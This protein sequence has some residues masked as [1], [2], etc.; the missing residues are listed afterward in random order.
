MSYFLTHPAVAIVVSRQGS[1]GSTRCEYSALI[2]PLSGANNVPSFPDCC[3]KSPRLLATFGDGLLLVHNSGPQKARASRPIQHTN[4]DIMFSQD[5]IHTDFATFSQ[6]SFQGVPMGGPRHPVNSPSKKRKMGLF[7]QVCGTGSGAEYGMGAENEAPSHFGVLMS[8]DSNMFS[9]MSQDFSDRFRNFNMRSCSSQDNSD[10]SIMVDD[11]RSMMSSDGFCIQQPKKMV[12]TPYSVLKPRSSNTASVGIAMSQGGSSSSGSGSGGSSSSSGK[13]SSSGSGGHG[14][15][16]A[17]AEVNKHKQVVIPAPVDNPFAP[18]SD[19]RKPSAPTTLWVA[20]FKDRPRYVSDFEHVRDIGM[21][22]FSSIFCARRR[23]DG[24]LYAV[25]RIAKKIASEKEGR[26]VIREACA[27]AALVGCP[28]LVQYF[29]CWLDDG[30]LHIQTEF[31]DVGSMEVFVCK[32]TRD[33]AVPATYACPSSQLT[34][35]QFSSS[36]GLHS[37]SSPDALES[38]DVLHDDD[39][40]LAVGNGPAS[41]QPPPR[42]GGAGFDDA[43]AWLVLARVAEVRHRLSSPSPSRL[44]PRDHLFPHPRSFP[45]ALAFM[46]ARGIVHLD[47]RPANIFLTTG[48]AHCPEAA[49]EVRADVPRALTDGRCLVRVGDLGH[50]VVA[51]RTPGAEE[52]WAEGESRYAARELINGALVACPSVVDLRAADVFSLGATLYE[53]CLGRE[54]GSAAGGG[55]DGVAEWHA[56]R[57]GQLDTSF[58]SAFCA[59]L[60]GLVR[61]MLH[62]DPALRPGMADVASYAGAKAGYAAAA[63]GCGA[64]HVA[65]LEDE[66]ARLQEENR[67]L[68]ERCGAAGH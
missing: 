14:G 38:S 52:D 49:D 60:V 18:A 53:L 66:V 41:Q 63:G 39:D 19:K 55:D 56:L 5:T 34:D 32:A 29:G 28:H 9:Q 64:G 7:S 40:V 27:H 68:R 61:Q 11:A 1:R 8:Q 23:L 58:E 48:R 25:K 4:R 57:D 46:H 44:A 42:R 12:P 62:P 65:A 3:I 45:Q 43:V 26:L 54:L 30:H 31:C 17:G 6:S 21:G 51:D 59:D 36:S 20:P 22:T 37:S 2:L 16:D 15:V 67:L 47:L 10:Y 50:A 33:G 35:S 24:V 13:S